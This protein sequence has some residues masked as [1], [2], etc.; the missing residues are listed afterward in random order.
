M[1]DKKQH[2]KITNNKTQQISLRLPLPLIKRIDAASDSN[3]SGFI[4]NAISNGMAIHDY[5]VLMQL[6]FKLQSG[7][8]GLVQIAIGKLVLSMTEEGHGDTE[9]ADVLNK[10]NTLT[11]MLNEWTGDSL[12]QFRD[13]YLS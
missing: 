11:T 12:K 10:Y 5:A 6:P 13:E 1:K 8:V 3:R 7:V 9:I 2:T 4:K